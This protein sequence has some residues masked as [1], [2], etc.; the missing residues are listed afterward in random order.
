MATYKSTY[1]R[2]KVARVIPMRLI[3]NLKHIMLVRT[4][5]QILQNGNRKFGLASI[6]ESVRDVTESNFV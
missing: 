1:A 6:A 2:I 4:I 3:Y 5:E